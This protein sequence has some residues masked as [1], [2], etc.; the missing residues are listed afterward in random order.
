MIRRPPRS[1]LFPYTT[2]FRSERDIEGVAEPDEARGLVGRVDHQHAALD[3]RLVGDDAHHA[4][5]DAREPDDDLAREQ[6]F[7]LEPRAG[8]DHAI[9]DL[10]HV[11]PLALIVRDD[12]VDRATRLGL[13]G[14]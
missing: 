7:H 14:N 3:L 11:K 2:L 1:T 9:D 4:S 6:L 8:I 13:S 5:V 12:L 10:V